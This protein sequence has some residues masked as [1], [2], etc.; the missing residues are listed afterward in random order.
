MDRQVDRLSDRVRILDRHL[1]VR[2]FEKQ[3]V[4]KTARYP[5]IRQ[6]ANQTD[7]QLESQSDRHTDSQ[8][9]NQRVRQLVGSSIT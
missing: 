6:I 4:S 7:I 2:Q 8:T 5:P 3:R 9:D 1:E